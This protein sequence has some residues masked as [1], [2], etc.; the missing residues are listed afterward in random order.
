MPIAAAHWERDVPCLKILTIFARRRE[1][2]KKLGE[3]I[4]LTVGQHSVPPASSLA[5]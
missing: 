4:A 3:R 1:I 2:R 5:Q